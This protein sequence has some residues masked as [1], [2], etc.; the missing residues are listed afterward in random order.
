M[1]RLLRR[2]RAWV[3]HREVEADLADE[4][5]FHRAARQDALERDGR[6]ARG[7]EAE[8][9]RVMGNITL[10]RED[11]RGVW[12]TPWIESLGQDVAYAVR[13]LA[14]QPGFAALAIST[15]TAGIGLTVSL[16]TIYSALAIRPWAVRDPERVVRVLNL[17]ALDMRKRAV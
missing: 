11:A 1:A 15:L 2:L 10:A 3:R 17:S 14:R 9:R 7:A 6:S 8:S 5:E 16:F 12:L 13:T 4:M